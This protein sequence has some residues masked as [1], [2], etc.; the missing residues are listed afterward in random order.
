M[1][2]PAGAQPDPIPFADVCA[3]LVR[4]PFHLRMHEIAALTDEQ[5]IA[6]YLRADPRDADRR[7]K[8]GEI[9]PGGK[10]VNSYRDLFWDTWKA[11]GLTDEQ[12]EARWTD[13]QARRPKRGNPRRDKR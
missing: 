2:G 3:V 10:V 9:P 5:L 1:S 7:P 6:V 13:Y 11:R 8:V 4:E 12:I